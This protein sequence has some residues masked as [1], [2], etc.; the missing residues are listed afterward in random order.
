MGVALLLGT[1]TRERLE[2][3][4]DAVNNAMKATTRPEALFDDRKNRRKKAKLMIFLVHY[5]S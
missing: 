1:G 2:V 4:H 5:E 3:P